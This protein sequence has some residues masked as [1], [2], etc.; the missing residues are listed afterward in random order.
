MLQTLLN[1]TWNPV[2]K[3]FRDLLFAP[4]APEADVDSALKRFSMTD[5]LMPYRCWVFPTGSV[6]QAT[7]QAFMWTYSGILAAVSGFAGKVNTVSSPAA[8]NS[9]ANPTSVSGVS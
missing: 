3:Y 7:R 1:Y 4:L 6:D 5:L 8:V 9:V 2:Y